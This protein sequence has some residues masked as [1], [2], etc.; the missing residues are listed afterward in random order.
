MA[1]S[2]FD[3]FTPVLDQT[4]T[5]AKEIREPLT[6]MIANANVANSCPCATIVLDVPMEPLAAGE[7]ATMV[8]RLPKCDSTLA[9][10]MIQVSLLLN[11]GTDAAAAATT[12]VDAAA[13]TSIITG[14]QRAAMTL[15]YDPTIYDTLTIA[16]VSGA[17]DTT[18]WYTTS[19][20][21]EAPASPDDTRTFEI[22]PGVSGGK[23]IA[24]SPLL[25]RWMAD[26]GERAAARPGAVVT[27][28]N[29][30]ETGRAYIEINSPSAYRRFAALVPTRV[31]AG[32]PGWR[33]MV[34]G[35]DDDAG[36]GG[37]V[38]KV[39]CSTGDYC[40]IVL[41]NQAS[42]A[43]DWEEADLDLAVPPATMTEYTLNISAQSSDVTRIAD[44]TIVE[45]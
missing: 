13:W 38:L 23:K 19:A 4:I 18:D 7:M 22:L 25:M 45:R 30:E 9:H 43:G 6:T 28:A 33:V 20:W 44:L 10:P 36:A 24:V 8:Y 34:R 21:Q 37:G 3:E 42:Y 41:P 2:D 26:A 11:I 27:L 39:E 12:S 40:E 1:L 35:Y 29:A 31:R 17:T 14:T 15:E 5:A 32:C 16:V